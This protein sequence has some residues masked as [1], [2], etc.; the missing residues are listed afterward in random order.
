M[1]TLSIW[2]DGRLVVL[3]INTFYNA[4]IDISQFQMYYFVNSLMQL[5]YS[6]SCLNLTQSNLLELVSDKFQELVIKSNPPCPPMVSWR[7]QKLSEMLRVVRFP[8]ARW[9]H[10][11]SKQFRAEYLNVPSSFVSEIEPSKHFDRPM[12]NEFDVFLWLKICL[13]R[14]CLLAVQ[15][16]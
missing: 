5:N 9:R 14:D 12:L 11:N 8:A 7:H 1:A 16:T 3:Y 4:L 10:K 6:P 15:S 2:F 13:G